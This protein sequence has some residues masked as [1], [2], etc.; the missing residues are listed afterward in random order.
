MNGACLP[1]RLAL[2]VGAAEIRLRLRFPRLMWWMTSRRP[3][4]PGPFAELQR[5]KVD[6]AYRTLFLAELDTAVSDRLAQRAATA[7]K[8]SRAAELL[9]TCVDDDGRAA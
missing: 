8:G 1:A 7:D 3:E 9:R 6:P 4:P 5:I 2:A